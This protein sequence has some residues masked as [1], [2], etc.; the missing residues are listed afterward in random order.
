MS[1]E[2]KQPD[3]KVEA[4]VIEKGHTHRGK[5][6]EIGDRITLRQTQLKRF[7]RRL[8]AAGTVAV[9]QGKAAAKAAAEV[10]RDE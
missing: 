4:E 10:A 1:N 9:T 3:P 7:A 5:V 2:T 6:C 8:R